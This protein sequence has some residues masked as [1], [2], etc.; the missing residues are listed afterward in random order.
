MQIATK[1]L[2]ASRTLRLIAAFVAAVLTSWLADAAGTV[3]SLIALAFA[4]GFAWLRT[5]TTGPL[6]AGPAVSW[7]VTALR[8]LA[9][10]GR[11][12]P[13]VPAELAV[14]L[15]L[16]PDD[17]QAW[18]KLLQANG[19]LRAADEARWRITPEGDALM[20]LLGSPSQQPRP[21]VARGPATSSGP[22][23]LTAL[24]M[25]VALFSSC[26]STLPT[27]AIVPCAAGGD[28]VTA[29]D[30]GAM[31]TRAA[32]CETESAAIRSGVF[33]ELFTRLA[34]IGGKR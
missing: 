31:R 13:S 2:T 14:S 18:I 4:V 7:D 20:T 24:V 22:G 12:G 23:S 33:T 21:P 25:A 32:R 34:N 26:G 17:V 16:Q 15:A 30:Y 8:I 3:E 6:S 10:L 29:A 27:A 1:P 5:A 28:C 9:E 11:A 19:Y